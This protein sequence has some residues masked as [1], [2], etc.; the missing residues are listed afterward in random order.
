MIDHPDIT[1]RLIEKLNDALPNRCAPDAGT[2]R[3][4]AKPEYRL[5]HP[6]PRYRHMDQL[7]GRRRRHR[8]QAR[9][10]AEC[11][12]RR[13]HVHHP[14]ALRSAATVG[15]PDHG[16]SKAPRPPKPSDNSRAPYRTVY[17]GVQ[18]HR[19][20]PHVI[21]DTVASCALTTY[22]KSPPTSLAGSVAGR[23]SISLRSQRPRAPQ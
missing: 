7:R 4:T 18:D 13:V 20:S 16:L 22:R 8:L 3:R 14:F 19:R 15:T 11:R 10:R 5:D 6:S 23:T 21:S 1:E 12:Q 9:S 2:A 17:V